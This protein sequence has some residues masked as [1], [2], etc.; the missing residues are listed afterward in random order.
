[1]AQSGTITH[2]YSETK[3]GNLGITTSQMMLTSELQL[4]LNNQLKDLILNAFIDEYTYY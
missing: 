2:V 3:S 1:M 4:R